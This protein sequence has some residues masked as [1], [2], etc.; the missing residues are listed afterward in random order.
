MTHRNK[1]DFECCEGL[2]HRTLLLKINVKIP[3]FCVFI[4]SRPFSWGKNRRKIN[5]VVYQ[6][7]EG[8]TDVQTTRTY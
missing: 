1:N 2:T 8:H 3:P 6:D 7:V 5:L 4:Y